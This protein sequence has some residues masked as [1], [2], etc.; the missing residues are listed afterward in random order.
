MNVRTKFQRNEALQAYFYL[1]FYW[2]SRKNG[3]LPWNVEINLLIVKIFDLSRYPHKWSHHRSVIFSTSLSLRKSLVWPLTRK[4]HTTRKVFFAY[5][6]TPLVWKSALPYHNWIQADMS[7][8]KFK[9]LFR[10][11][12]THINRKHNNISKHRTEL[13]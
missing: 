6:P 10:A 3:M 8:S 2:D 7:N 1:Y 13:E 11:K 9:T 5:T 12:I 4:M